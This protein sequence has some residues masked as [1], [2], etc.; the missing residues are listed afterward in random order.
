MLGKAVN[1]SMVGAGVFFYSEKTQR[2]LFLLRNNTK[3]KNT[4]G[5]VGGKIQSSESVM[6]GLEREVL[7]EI[8]IKPIVLKKI[9]LDS[10]TSAD[11]TFTYHSFIFVVEEEFI[12][13]LNDEHD[14]YCWVTLEKYPKPLHPGV[15][16]SI[17]MDVIINKIKFIKDINYKKSFEK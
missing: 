14:G 10:F 3:T 8:G 17:N 6:E 5:L 15:W 13:I 12:P 11:E 4:W 2:F 1:K 7:E 9:P 16:N